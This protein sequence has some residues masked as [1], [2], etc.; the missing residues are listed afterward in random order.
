MIDTT[1][2]MANIDPDV[3][4]ALQ[5]LMSADYR[6]A[7]ML[8]DEFRIGLSPYGRGPSGLAGYL[9]QGQAFQKACELRDSLTEKLDQLNTLRAGALRERT[10]EI[11]NALSNFD[12]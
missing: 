9:T 3:A 12:K 10:L 8:Y 11:C 2:S 1:P 4:E 5:Q 6:A 7:K